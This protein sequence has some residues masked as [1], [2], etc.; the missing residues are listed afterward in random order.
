MQIKS[1][2]NILEQSWSS[3]STLKETIKQ[4]DYVIDAQRLKVRF[5]SNIHY[6]QYISYFIK[7]SGRKIEICASNSWNN[8]FPSISLSEILNNELFVKLCGRDKYF[9]WINRQR[10]YL[11]SLILSSNIPTQK[12]TFFYCQN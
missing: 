12:S 3:E 5:T 11:N 6:Y 7:T 1:L 10:T 9:F 2:N 4:R 8:H